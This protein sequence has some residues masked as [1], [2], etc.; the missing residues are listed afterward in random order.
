MKR[1]TA[2]IGPGR[3]GQFD[4]YKDDKGDIFVASKEAARAGCPYQTREYVRAQDGAV[5][6]VRGPDTEVVTSGDE[7]GSTIEPGSEG[8]YSGG[9]GGP[10]GGETSVGAVGTGDIW[11]PPTGLAVAVDATTI[12]KMQQHEQWLGM[13]HN[14]SHSACV[15]PSQWR[16]PK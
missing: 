2:E 7:E 9:A 12:C 4:L 15:S 1:Q 16:S 8:G 11:G 3:G 5:A 13:P 6:N 10:S 14:A